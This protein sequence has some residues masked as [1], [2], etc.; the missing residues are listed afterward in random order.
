MQRLEPAFCRARAQHLPRRHWL[1]QALQRDGAEFPAVEQAADLPPCGRIHHHLSRSSAA[2]QP[3]RAIWCL[4][5]RR[6]L[7]RIPRTNRLADDY[8]AGGD[9]D[10]DLE[11]LSA[12]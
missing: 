11:W 2:L 4:A 8:K 3:G 10:A 12:R 6:L 5:N 7:T 9:A 1:G